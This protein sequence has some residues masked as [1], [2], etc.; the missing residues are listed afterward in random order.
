MWFKLWQIFLVSL[1]VYIVEWQLCE[2]GKL[3]HAN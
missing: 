3:W 1:P 2:Q